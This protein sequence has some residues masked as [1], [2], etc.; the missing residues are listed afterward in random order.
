MWDYEFQECF[1][2]WLRKKLRVQKV[3]CLVGIRTQE[4]FNRWR[5]I[6]RSTPGPSADW[7]CPVD[8][9]IDNVYPLYDWYTTDIWTANGR[10]CRKYNRLYDLYYQAGVPLNS[11]RIASS[12][13][14]QAIPSL[15]LYRMIEPEMWGKMLRRVNSVNFARVYGNSVA[16][17][18]RSVRLPKEMT[19]KKYFF[20]LLGTLPEGYQEQLSGQV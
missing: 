20:S 14:S 17:G 10:F 18:W 8:E 3:A 7:V 12:F 9:G 5:T 16:M 6:Y 13:I 2:F 1:A 4:S 19:W 15:H 11:Q